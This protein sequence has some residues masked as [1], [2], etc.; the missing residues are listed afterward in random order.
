MRFEERLR[1]VLEE[2]IANPETNKNDID[3]A[4]S[5]IRSLVL[6]LIPEEKKDC[7]VGICEANCCFNEC[8]EEMR[9][10]VNGG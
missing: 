8:R 7:G 4:I 10:R 6:E 2:E 1:A 9:R 5:A 3:C